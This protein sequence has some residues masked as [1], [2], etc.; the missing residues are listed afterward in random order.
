MNQLPMP[1]PFELI[2]AGACCLLPLIV[3]GVVVVALLA[4]GRRKE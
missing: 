1:G 2:F 3:A 4:F